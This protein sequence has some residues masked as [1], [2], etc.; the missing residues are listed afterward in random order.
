MLRVKGSKILGPR[1]NEV[2]IKKPYKRPFTLHDNMHH[3]NPK[4]TY[5]KMTLNY[6]NYLLL[7]ILGALLLTPPSLALRNLNQPDDKPP[8]SYHI[9]AA[10]PIG[11]I[12]R[13]TPTIPRIPRTKYFPPGRG[14]PPAADGTGH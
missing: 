13:P 1:M 12:F 5:L 7:L 14:H 4:S 2:M 8:L 10:R 11:R 3:P 6:L 9:P